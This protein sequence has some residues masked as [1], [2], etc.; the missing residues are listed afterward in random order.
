M[1]RKLSS[2]S[3]GES[4][5]NDNNGG[6]SGRQVQ[7]SS[8]L[9]LEQSTRSA[10]EEGFPLDQ[11]LAQIMGMLPGEKL[12]RSMFYGSP[13][14]P[15][16]SDLVDQLLSKQEELLR[17][18]QLGEGT[19][20]STQHDMSGSLSLAKYNA[21][22]IRALVSSI[23]APTS[24]ITGGGVGAVYGQPGASH[25]Q[26]PGAP[27]WQGPSAPHWQGPSAPGH[28]TIDS[29]A[30]FILAPYLAST[31]GM[32]PGERLFRGMFHGTQQSRVVLEMINH[33]SEIQRDL[34]HNREL[35]RAGVMTQGEFGLS[36]EDTSSLIATNEE[37]LEALMASIERPTETVPSIV[38]DSSS[39]SDSD[40]ET[41]L[42]RRTLDKL[43]EERNLRLARS[44]ARLEKEK[45]EQGVVLAL[46]AA[47]LRETSLMEVK[48]RVGVGTRGLGVEIPPSL[49]EI[50]RGLKAVTEKRKEISSILG[51]TPSRNL[52][53]M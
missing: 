43:E 9:E 39:N 20:S 45:V 19:S 44:Q 21:R 51:L 3:S 30:G 16:I 28:S 36:F 24:V 6:N 7:Q 52:Q 46:R 27:H 4:S 31:L 1:K 33:L 34:L 2:T 12:F 49:I 15:Y 35:E 29:D 42:E 48:N 38:V 5:L 11:H 53:E 32:R 50:Y 10:E 17:R 23:E 8:A 25:W 41:E 47:K 13:R 37:L 26:D 22:V 14:A 18:G 40:S